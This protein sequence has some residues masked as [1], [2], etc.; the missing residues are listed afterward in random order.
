MSARFILKEC[1]EPSAQ[2]CEFAKQIEGLIAPHQNR[3]KARKPDDQKRYD[4]TLL[5]FS[6]ALAQQ[7]LMPIW[8]QEGVPLT[9][10]HKA[11][12]GSPLSV[13]ALADIRDSAE[14]AG[15][16]AVQKGFFDKE[17]GD[18][19][20]TRIHPRVG[21]QSLAMKCDLTSAMLV[22]APEITTVLNDPATDQVMPDE[23]AS[24]DAIV[25]RFNDQVAHADIKLTASALELARQRASEAGRTELNVKGYDPGKVYLTRIFKGTWERGGRLYGGAWQNLPQ[26]ARLGLTINGEAVV[27]L[28]YGAIQPSMLYA[29][30]GLSLDFDPYIVPGFDIPREVGK[31]QFNRLIN[32][33]GKKPVKGGLKFDKETQKYFSN[34]DQFHLYIYAMKEMH[35]AI[36]DFFSSDASL[37]LQYLDSSLALS[38][39]NRCLDEGIVCLPVHDSFIVPEPHH[40]RLREIMLSEYEATFNQQ[41]VVH[42]NC[43]NVTGNI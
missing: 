28:D 11:Y 9:F 31:V 30:K 42:C 6:A 17:Q 19:Q 2:I 8:A 23:V 36:S 16:I 24:E 7:A 10:R 33:S 4:A 29:Q 40:D 26:E 34:R 38:V 43:C 25:R 35:T 5:A 37:K 21:A 22:H 1:S 3:K 27:E 39:I 20:V 12:V 41:I 18:G 13:T 14:K 15:L 32:N